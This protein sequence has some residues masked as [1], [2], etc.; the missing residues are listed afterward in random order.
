MR[1]GGGITMEQSTAAAV[2]RRF[3]D[4]EAM[5]KGR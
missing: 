5:V 3:P 1:I 2:T 4:A